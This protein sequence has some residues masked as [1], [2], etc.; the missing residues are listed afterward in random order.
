MDL[1]SRAP[2][3]TMQRPGEI[4]EKAT[5]YDDKESQYCLPKRFQDRKNANKL[6]AGDECNTI[7]DKKNCCKVGY[8]VYKTQK[9]NRI[10]FRIF[11]PPLIVDEK[12]NVV[13][14]PVSNR[15]CKGAPPLGWANFGK[16]Y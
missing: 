6:C 11:T 15:R 12:G 8:F 1:S 3:S 5:T 13:D 14:H 16:T 2:C 10:V 9:Y 4:Q 7:V